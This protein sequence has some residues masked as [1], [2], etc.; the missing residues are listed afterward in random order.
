MSE[1]FSPKEIRDIKEA[2][3]KLE[4]MRKEW[5]KDKLEVFE[6]LLQL[7]AF[8]EWSKD[9]III[10]REVNHLQREI[11]I[12]VIYK[13]GYKNN[14]TSLQ[15]LQEIDQII[16]DLDDMDPA[17]GYNKLCKIKDVIDY[18]PELETPS[19][20]ENENVEPN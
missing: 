6:Q 15:R 8:I 19:D 11:L 12:T 20:K 9:N 1:K 13:G 5:G 7:P 16:G 17:D 2:A 3:A 18:Q 14:K 4:K 10:N